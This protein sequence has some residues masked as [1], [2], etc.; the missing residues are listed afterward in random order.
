M[1]Q[2]LIYLFGASVVALGTVALIAQT[3]EGGP[4]PGAFPGRGTVGRG[5]RGRGGR[6]TPPQ[7]QLIKGQP[8]DTREPEKKDDHPAFP[9]QTRAPYEP[10]TQPVV[11]VLT[12]KLNNPWS[13]A[14]LPDGKV[15]ITEKPGAMR[16]F[17][18]KDNSLSE[19]LGG[20]PKVHYQGQVGLLD[21]ALDPKFSSNR[22]IFFS[23]MEDM[24]E[25]DAIVMATAKLAKD[26]SEITGVDV[27]FRATPINARM[28][29]AN[30]G[31][32]I[33]IG[34]D[35]N[36]F[37]TVGD[38]SGSP[39]WDMAQKLDNT[40]GKIIHIT[41][42][43]KPAPGNPFIGQAGKAPE[44]WSYGHR[45]EE[46]LTINPANGELWE[47]EHGPRGGDK[48]LQPEKGKNYGWPVYNHGID[49]P[50]NPIGAGITEA[51]GTEQPLYYWDPVIAPSGLAFYT[52]NKFPEW[53]N[54]IFVG[55]L[56]G[57]MLDR[58]HLDGEKVIGEEPLLMNQRT[59]I[60]DV[61]MG[62]DGDVYI[63]TDANSFMK[64][65]PK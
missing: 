28:H 11:T 48:L 24:G 41:P 58:L 50:G 38:G 63:L 6:G 5:G 40:V 36:I 8:I 30:R 55:A 53:K 46:G 12:D 44:I 39:P 35:G 19:P 13:F 7:F 43:G 22:R 34:R 54:S 25:N 2:R 29:G 45:S 52:G 59:R 20:V 16:T 56:G 10:T 15:L 62:P 61:R 57:Q 37:M 26:D 64:L 60:R 3:P 33:A 49:Y 18:P 17:N 47:T 14:F 4:P 32:R 1:K 9:G 42:E 21:L 51:P 31:G 27:I 65:S 23:Y